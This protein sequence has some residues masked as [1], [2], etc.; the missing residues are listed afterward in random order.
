EI[1]NLTIPYGGVVYENRPEISFVV[2]D[3]L[4]GIADDRNFTILVD[5]EWVI[6]EYDKESGNCKTRPN[7]SLGSGRHV[8]KIKVTDRA[9]NVVEQHVPFRVQL[10]VEPDLK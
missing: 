8:Y 5:D 3:T 7:L 6:P 9:G 10:E 2:M 1:S 4:S